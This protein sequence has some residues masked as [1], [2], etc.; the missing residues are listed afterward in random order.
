MVRI[1]SFLPADITCWE[2]G[3][4]LWPGSFNVDIDGTFPFR[5]VLIS[6]MFFTI[7]GY[8]PTHLE[9]SIWSTTHFEWIVGAHKKPATKIQGPVRV[10]PKNR[11]QLRARRQVEKSIRLLFDASETFDVGMD[12]GAPVSLLYLD[13]RRKRRWGWIGWCFCWMRLMFF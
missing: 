7:P 8:H 9:P 10:A 3:R 6:N 5:K 2:L 11:H 13:S 1:A 4:E 12:L